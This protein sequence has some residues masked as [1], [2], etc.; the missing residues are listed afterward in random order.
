MEIHADAD[1]MRAMRIDLGNACDCQSR[2]G[3]RYRSA[4][5]LLYNTHPRDLPDLR[6]FDKESRKLGSQ[7]NDR[8]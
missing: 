6:R 8:R 1:V 3:S 2:A 7:E 4:A 5:S